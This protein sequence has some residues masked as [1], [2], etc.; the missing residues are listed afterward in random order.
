MRLVL[1]TL[2]TASLILPACGGA[3]Q[4]PQTGSI[5]ANAST[6]DL[7]E[8]IGEFPPEPEFV[9]D[10]DRRDVN[11]GDEFSLLFDLPDGTGSSNEWGV[12]VNY[13]DANLKHLKTWYSMEGVNKRSNKVDLKAV[14]AGEVTLTYAVFE[15]NAPINDERRTIVI[16]IK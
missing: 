4:T 15:N 12:I 1:I 11:V 5:D 2:L 14:G 7:D 9:K 13:P 8:M 16:N 10:G 6:P 3:E